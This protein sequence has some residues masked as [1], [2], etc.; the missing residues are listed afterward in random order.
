MLVSGSVSV[1]TK[2]KPTSVELELPFFFL[3]GGRYPKVGGCNDQMKK[4]MR[5]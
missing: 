1:P 4:I 5:K 2:N 3:G